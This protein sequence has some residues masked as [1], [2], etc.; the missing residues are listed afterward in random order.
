MSEVTILS[1]G[2]PA[3]G[4]LWDELAED[5]RA[6]PFS[7]RGWFEAWSRSFETPF[8]V[9]VFDEGP[10]L[11]PIVREGRGVGT[12]VNQE[13][14]G[15]DV[16][17][18]SSEARYRLLS[19][20]IASTAGTC[21]FLK[22]G[23]ADA[24]AIRSASGKR[25][26]LGS[27]MQRSPFLE[28]AGPWGDYESSLSSSFR[29]GLRRKAR[30]LRTEGEVT[31][32]RTDG[33]DDL[34]RLLDEGFE[35]ESSRWKADQGTAIASRPETRDFYASVARWAAENHWLNLWFLRLNGRSIAF[36]FDLIVEGVYYHLKGGYDPA[37]A[38]HSPGLLLQHETIRHAFEQRLVRYEFL[39]A[40]EPYKM[41]WAKDRRDRISIQVFGTGLRGGAAWLS[42]AYARPAAKRL[43]RRTS[44][45]AG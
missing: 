9:A 15:F 1:A 31:I 38:R 28:I 30:R 40:D 39:G 3:V 34:G 12:P 43:L 13:T 18:A 11:I 29:Q 44:G 7:R 16:L 37:L 17:A 33:R 42:T 26:L 10:A 35:V 27:V 36:R 8:E 20:L 25:R 6:E 45:S 19:G 21:R 4:A 22:V 14:P 23:S 32:E 5:T 2:D 24:A 41:N